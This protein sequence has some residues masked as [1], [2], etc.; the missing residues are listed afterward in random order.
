LDY[1]QIPDDLLITAAGFQ[2][3]GLPEMKPL[4]GEG[5]PE[6]VQ[7]PAPFALREPESVTE[8]TFHGLTLQIC[9]KLLDGSPKQ[10][11]VLIWE[12]SPGLCF[13]S[14]PWADGID[15]YVINQSDMSNSVGETSKD[16][17]SMY[18]K[19]TAFPLPWGSRCYSVFAYKDIAGQGR[20]YSP[21]AS[22]CGELPNPEK[23]ILAPQ[24]W[25]STEG[26]P[27][28]ED[29][30]YAASGAASEKPTGSN[31]I[32]VGAYAQ[33][34]SG[35]NRRTSSNAAVKFETPPLAQGAVIHRALLRF[36]RVD[37]SWWYPDEVAVAKG[38][39]PGNC[40]SRIGIAKQD[41]T[42]L[43]SGHFL[44][45]GN[46]LGQ[47]PYF[48]PYTDGLALW[49]STVELD[50]TSLVLNW[51]KEPDTNYGFILA[52]DWGNMYNRGVA[53]KDWDLKGCY[54]LLD[55][56]EL[57]IQYFAP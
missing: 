26:V 18:Q 21:P 53:E 51:M 28:E 5:I 36:N 22:Y 42:G 32:M 31:Q 46:T 14:C 47:A 45:G 33:G 40:V 50:V 49:P 3:Q 56:V 9:T 30:S 17:A 24:D 35:C 23:L 57:E 55:N 15:G 16:I 20:V 25:L 27:Y 37:L 13:G 6:D 4:E 48:S 52:G 11:I 41:W 1:A 44:Q 38:E 2:A 8:C 19:A 34:G 10:Y 43:S 29:C 39:R 12:W 7:L 54:S